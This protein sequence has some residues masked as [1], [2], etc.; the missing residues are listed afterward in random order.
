MST[1]Q[2]TQ[3]L[4]NTEQNEKNQ[5]MHKQQNEQK[6]DQQLEDKKDVHQGHPKTS[7][8]DGK[9]GGPDFMKETVSSMGKKTHEG[10]QAD[11]TKPTHPENT[12]F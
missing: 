4:I 7:A 1:Y 8:V 11:H 9:E 3:G 2:S 12:K 10:Y 5:A 6:S